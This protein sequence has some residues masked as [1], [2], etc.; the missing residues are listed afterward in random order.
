MYAINVTKMGCCIVGLFLSAGSFC[1]NVE[2][3]AVKNI[4]LSDPVSDVVTVVLEGNFGPAPKVV[5]YNDFRDEEPL[6]SLSKDKAFVGSTDW[7]KSTIPPTVGV[8]KDQPG[9]FV[10]DPETDKVAIIYAGLGGAYEKIFLAYSIAIPNK[11]T[12]P[13]INN[14][15]QWQ[16]G[17][18]W[19]LAWMLESP[20]AYTR[21]EEFDMRALR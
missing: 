9:F 16:G 6:E 11:S 3:K 12:A 19:K 10:I 5:Y 7:H 15:E 14:E 18:N 20:E 13:M 4:S 21:A 17:S 1:A 2:I 8:Y